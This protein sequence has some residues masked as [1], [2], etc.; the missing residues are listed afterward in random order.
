MFFKLISNNPDLSWILCKRPGSVYEKTYET[1]RTVT[2]S[3]SSD[4]EYR[5]LVKNDLLVFT[6]SMKERNEA[7]Y[8][9]PEPWI[10]C[11]FNLR[12]LS[13]CLRSALFGQNGSKSTFPQEKFEL[14]T[15]QQ[16]E[17]GPFP[18]MSKAFVEALESLK[19]Q[20]TPTAPSPVDTVEFVEVYTFNTLEDMSVSEFLQKIYI[21]SLAFTAKFAWNTHI[22]NEQVDKYVRLSSSWING[23]SHKDMIVKKLTKHMASLVKQFEDGTTNEETVSRENS[24]DSKDVEQKY[25]L[26]HAR[27][28]VLLATVKTIFSEIT[29]DRDFYKVV[30]VGT[31]EG[32]LTMELLSRFP[33]ELKVLSVDAD[34][35]KISRL[36]KY[37]RKEKLS[38]DNAWAIVE[39]IAYPKRWHREAMNAD[40]VIATEILEHLHQTDRASV[41]SLLKQTN[42]KNILITVPNVGYNTIYGIPAGEFRHKDHRIEYDLESFLAEIVAPLTDRYDVDLLPI[43]EPQSY[44]ASVIAK[45]GL[46]EDESKELIRQFSEDVDP[47]LLQPSFFIRAKRKADAEESNPFTSIMYDTLYY[48][49]TNL[50]V[51]GKDLAEG[52]KTSAFLANANEIFYLGPTLPP[53]DY[54]EGDTC[55]EHPNTAFKYFRERGIRYVIEQQK[56]M[57]SRGYVLCFK[58]PE[59][60]QEL[61]FEHA[62]TV[63]SRSGVRFFDRGAPE[64]DA[65]YRDLV[66]KMKSDFIM[67]D[68]EILP[69]S[70]K[71]DSLIERDFQLPGEA[72]LI[73]RNRFG[74]EAEYTRSAAFL[75]SLRN[76]TEKRPV[77]VH[78]F[79]VL[80]TGDVWY[81]DGR[82]NRNPFN[83]IKLGFYQD[84]WEQYCT[85][86]R[87]LEGDILKPVKTVRVDTNDE[88]FCDLSATAW[89][90]YCAKG[91]EGFV[92]KPCNPITFQENGFPNQTALKVRGK[93]YLRLIYGI[94]YLEPEL[95]KS[96]TERGTRRKRLLAAQEQEIA[97]QILHSFVNGAT[98]SRLRNIAAFFSLEH[99]VGPTVDKTL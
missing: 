65:I 18:K 93:E 73:W 38:K 83:N 46:S 50:I 31:S 59:A 40:V 47:R 33:N 12:G 80:A 74:T 30:D 57:G 51:S 44:L 58:N 48:Q 95:F 1:G 56:L 29:E 92:Y 54:T 4:T 87:G 67:L 32:K 17:L 77:T 84:M 36:K 19:I 70:Y 5:L 11:P 63:N 39:N 75:A 61:G 76:Y 28:D 35:R 26:H 79:H 15:A 52:V 72:S 66:P 94:D 21:V 43:V 82:I 37:M 2:G 20:A 85:V 8:V 81:R 69:W 13:E 89:E 22:T 34:E 49:H 24:Q 88:F 98:L 10:V 45:R 64:L 16:A 55:L 14:K 3:F 9:R 25:T 27:H 41:L 7:A 23:C 86:L 91:G 71:A 60:A 53:V 68:A 42:A 96:L 6:Q 99:A 97:V 90:N 62:V 78:P